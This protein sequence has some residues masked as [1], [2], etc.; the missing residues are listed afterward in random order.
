MRTGAGAADESARGVSAGTHVS[1]RRFAR[2]RG[3]GAVPVSYT[4]LDVYKRQTEDIVIVKLK[5]V[6]LFK[7]PVQRFFE[8]GENVAWIAG[9]DNNGQKMCIRDSSPTQVLLQ[10]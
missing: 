2:A 3:A 9:Y 10:A 6:A 8:V 7:V 1:A 4:H 5:Q